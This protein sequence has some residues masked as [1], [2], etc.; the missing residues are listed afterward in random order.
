MKKLTSVCAV[1]MTL[2]VCG[3]APN[4]FAR[5]FSDLGCGTGYAPKRTVAPVYPMRARQ[6]GIE[7]YIVM[8]FSIASDG[9]VG[10]VNVVDAEPENTFVRSATQAVE[11]MEF[12][13][14]VINGKATEQSAVSIRFD[15]KLH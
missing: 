5:T 3:Y 9:S 12:P 11:N 2:L 7:G 10:D 15:F 8:G 6:R 13:P 4:T 14:C 1:A